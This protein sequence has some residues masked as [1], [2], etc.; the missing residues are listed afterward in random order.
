MPRLSLIVG[1]IAF[2]AL[3]CNDPET[4]LP[5]TPTAPGV[6]SITLS[7]HY[8]LP[9]GQSTQLTV[10]IRLTDGTVKDASSNTPLQWSTSNG[11]VLQV[12]SSGRITATQTLGEARITVRYG[13][14]SSQR[15]A[16]KEIVNVPEGTFRMVGIVRD[17]E[18]PAFVLGGV[19]VAATLGVAVATTN[20]AGEY[21][22]Y[23]VPPS[24]VIEISKAGYTPLT[25]SVQLTGHATRDFQLVLAGPRVLVSGLYTLTLDMAGGCPG[26]GSLSPDLQRRVYEATVTQNGPIVDVL[27]TEP[28]FRLN[29]ISRGN[30]FSGLAD[31]TSV[32]FNLDPFYSYYYPYYGPTAYP[33][34][35]EQLSNGTF[36]VPEGRAI[37]VASAAGVSGGFNALFYNYGPG[38]PLNIS[39][40][41]YCSSSSAQL[42]LTPR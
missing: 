22:L 14:G 41:G 39:I 33:N 9:P 36:L 10:T 37:V 5:T 15:S 27:L 24:A 30:R 25:Q 34:V 32:T 8:T 6:A 13:S 19:R 40:L 28:R 17:S 3:A 11:Q 31:G 12:S 42:T 35:A 18:S 16:F 4:R 20:P 38:F 1:L 21:R 2:T 7:G 29:T 23:G 26:G